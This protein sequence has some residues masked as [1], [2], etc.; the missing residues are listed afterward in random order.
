[1]SNKQHSSSQK[2]LFDDIEEVEGNQTGWLRKLRLLQSS[3]RDQA[4]LLLEDTLVIIAVGILGLFTFVAIFAPY[5]APYGQTERIIRSGEIMLWKKPVFLGGEGG[6]ILGTTSS[7]YDILSQLIWGT[8]PAM[9]VGFIAAILTVFVGT[10]LGLISGYYG[11]YVD[12]VI[13]R[14]VDFAYSIPLLPAVI[15]LVAVWGPGLLNLIVALVLLQWRT[16]ARVIRS[17]VL[18]LRERAFVRSARA[19]GAS[20][21]R[22]IFY[23]I[24]PNIL[25][26]TFLYAA[27]SVV[28]AIL[29][30]A[31]VAFLGLGDPTIPSWGTMLQSARTNNALS[32]G[33]WWWFVPPGI[34]IG[35]VAVSA[36]IIG[37]KYEE[38]INPELQTID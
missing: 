34:C 3:V 26:L 19:S 11:G 27:F 38:V 36:F 4:S 15:I 9:L 33:A 21:A 5:L 29:T 32:Q 23:H 30:E 12:D 22:I 31:S 7:G 1:M 6:F 17:Q 18:T 24:A 35:L 10:V 8:R 28:F 20:D 16:S 13:M 14:M 37:R 25:P 2:S